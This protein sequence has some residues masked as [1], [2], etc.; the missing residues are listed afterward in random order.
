VIDRR[1]LACS[2]VAIGLA[3]TLA[4]ALAATDTELLRSL[5][6]KVMRAH[7]EHNVELLLE[8][9]TSEYVVANKGEVTRPTLEERRAH[10]GSYLQSTAFEE[11]RDLVEPTVHVSQDGTLGWVIVQV[12]A[13]G[14]QTTQAGHKEPLEFVSAWI[15]LYR[16]RDGRWYRVGNVS[17]FKPWETPSP[18]KAP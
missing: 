11:Y 10:L 6:E 14:I 4:T 8:D 9:E 15:E 17:N 13:R 12:Q 16:K 2:L 3:H 18:G 5:H 1:R 7:R